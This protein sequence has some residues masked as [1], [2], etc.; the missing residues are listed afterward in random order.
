M[1]DSYARQ[2]D[3]ARGHVVQELGWDEDADSTIS[4]SIEDQIGEN[5]LDEDTDELCDVVLMW[6][7]DD[8]GDL[9][10]GLVDAT[11]NLEEAGRVWLLTPAAG[12]HGAVETG[13]IAE[14]AQLSGLVQTASVRLGDWQGACLVQRG[15]RKS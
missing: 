3:I 4:E 10:D 11:R 13:I 2:L 14:S 15:T 12:K 7:R 1:A 9:V 6:W 8:D 5:L